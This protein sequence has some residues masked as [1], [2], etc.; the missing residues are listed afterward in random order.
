MS[1][2][3]SPAIIYTEKTL[4]PEVSPSQK[5]VRNRVLKAILERLP[6]N[7][8]SQRKVLK[9]QAAMSILSPGAKQ[10]FIATVA[11]VAAE[12]GVRIAVNPGKKGRGCRA[13]IIGKYGKLPP[14]VLVT[15]A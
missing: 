9:R 6:E 7:A 3:S 2:T 10:S 14:F 4:D 13:Q 12:H 11:T 8:T 1:N 15:Q 5:T